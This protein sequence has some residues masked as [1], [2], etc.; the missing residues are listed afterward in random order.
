MKNKG[1]HKGQDDER[2]LR[3]R[4]KKEILDRHPL[5]HILRNT[6]KTIKPET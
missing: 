5:I 6:I 1:F 4:H 3:K 2:E